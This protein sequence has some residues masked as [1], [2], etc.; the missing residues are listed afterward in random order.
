MNEQE[1]KRAELSAKTGI[2]IEVI[3]EAEERLEAVA[4]NIDRGHIR[5]IFKSRD[6][7]AAVMKCMD[8]LHPG[9]NSA[10]CQLEPIA[11]EVTC[12][13]VALALMMTTVILLRTLDQEE[14]DILQLCTQGLE[15]A[16]CYETAC[17]AA[18][19]NPFNGLETP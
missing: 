9:L 11:E 19:L 2:P 5:S 18:K 3:R 13:Q 1:R 14:G 16:E 6:N 4:P 10:L 7:M 15:L 17:A 12:A 8:I